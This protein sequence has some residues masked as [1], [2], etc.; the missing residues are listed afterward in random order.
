[1]KQ[2][3]KKQTLVKTLLNS[4]YGNPRVRYSTNLPQSAWSNSDPDKTPLENFFN[5][6]S[7][8]QSAIQSSL[9][10]EGTDSDRA[11]KLF[12]EYISNMFDVTGFSVS[13]PDFTGIAE[14]PQD[15]KTNINKFESTL[16]SSYGAYIAR[17]SG[18]GNSQNNVMNLLAA[19]RVNPGKNVVIT[20]GDGH[21]SFDGGIVVGGIEVVPAKLRKDKKTGLKNINHEKRLTKLLMRHQKSCLALFVTLPTYEGG[22]I[23]LKRMHKKCRKLGIFLIVDGSWGALW[24]IHP[25]FPESLAKPVMPYV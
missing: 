20:Y 13:S 23:D 10:K 2:N 9:S 17:I 18:A 12:G 25:A 1:M 3:V 21:S 22:S 5:R 11:Q 6:Q 16:S 24:G 14:H 4:V 19:K 15:S 7:E 8:L